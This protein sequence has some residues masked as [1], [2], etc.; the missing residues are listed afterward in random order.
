M[1]G[2]LPKSEVRE[3][4]MEMLG[5]EPIPGYIGED[6]RYIVNSEFSV[7]FIF[8]N[9][10]EMD[11]FGKFVPIATYRERSITNIKIILDLFRAMDARKI[12][13]DKKTGVFQ[14]GSMEQKKQQPVEERKNDAP[15]TAIRR[16]LRR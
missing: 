2:G 16:L 14:L 8:K 4:E 6:A 3:L 11:L 1:S 12:T 7:R 13:Y 5:P 15:Q 9:Q 10:E